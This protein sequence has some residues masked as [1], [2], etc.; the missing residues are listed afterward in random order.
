MY[1]EQAVEPHDLQATALES[2]ENEWQRS[3]N[4]PTI[5][6]YVAVEAV[7]EQNDRTWS[8]AREYTPGNECCVAGFPIRGRG[9]PQDHRHVP[10]REHPRHEGRS[11]AVWRSEQGR[12]S[13][14][15]SFERPLRN[16][17]IGV[18]RVQ[19]T[20][21]VVVHRVTGKEMSLG[22]QLPADLWALLE[23]RARSEEGCVHAMLTENARDRECRGV[24][25]PV[26]EG[27]RDRVVPT[28]SM[29]VDRPEPRHSRIGRRHPEPNTGG[30]QH[31]GRAEQCGV[32][33]RAT[34]SEYA[35]QAVPAFVHATVP[36]DVDAAGL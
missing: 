18:S 1:A 19:P 28:R 23:G 31:D 12:T 25:G 29:R 30:E 2:F 34:C 36:H 26:V 35:L 8:D 13:T 9:V 11:S 22:D 6:V 4:D 17:E 33:P 20:P 16:I 14:D 32:A 3:H 5:R 7:V 27:Q 10:I 21:R 24:I 15:V